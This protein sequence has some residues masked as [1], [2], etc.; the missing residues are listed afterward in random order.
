MRFL[1]VG[2]RHVNA[3]A[4]Q[5]IQD[6]AAGRRG[7]VKPGLWRSVRVG[8]MT[9]EGYDPNIGREIRQIERLALDPDLVPRDIKI[10]QAAGYQPFNVFDVHEIED[11]GAGA[12]PN[13]VTLGQVF[14]LREVETELV[15]APGCVDVDLCEP[16][17]GFGPYRIVSVKGEHTAASC[18]KRVVSCRPAQN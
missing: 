5:R 8:V 13:M 14:H 11:I 4:F 9:V 15:I 7:Y 2:F 18:E 17:L 12:T 3:R 10:L 16:L 6:I 1:L